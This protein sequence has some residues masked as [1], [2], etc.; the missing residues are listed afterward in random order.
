MLHIRIYWREMSSRCA[1]II[2]YVLL[3]CIDVEYSRI[4]Y[5]RVSILK[6]LFETAEIP[7]TVSYL[8]E[9]GLFMKL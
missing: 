1:F 2:K 5:Y 7:K 8:K 4:K 3:N 6:E 9:I